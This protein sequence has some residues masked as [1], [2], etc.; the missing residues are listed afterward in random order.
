MTTVNEVGSKPHRFQWHLGYIAWHLGITLL[1]LA[2]FIFVLYRLAVGIIIGLGYTADAPLLQLFSLPWW[3][4]VGQ[5]V[6]TMGF[7][8]IY[9]RIGLYAI[10]FMHMYYAH[11]AF[12]VESRFVHWIATLAYYSSV[13]GWIRIW[14]GWHREHHHDVDGTHDRTSPV[15]YG[16]VHAHMLVWLRKHFL[17]PAPSKYSRHLD[18]PEYAASMALEPYY[19]PLALFMSLGVPVLV[20]SLWLDP[21][22]G[23]LMAGCFRLAALYH[24]TWTINSLMHIKGDRMEGAKSATNSHSRF[25]IWFI[26]GEP[27]HAR[28]HKWPT[29]YRRGAYDPGADLVEWLARRKLVTGLRLAPDLKK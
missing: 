16:W 3:G 18:K 25:L 21:I 6:L 12:K 2:G 7:A 23:L 26:V 22:G 9:F 28:H 14:A 24:T 15:V 20:C 13:Q 17:K 8:W 5:S 4:L 10:T 27:H 1:G 29:S 19:V 11:E